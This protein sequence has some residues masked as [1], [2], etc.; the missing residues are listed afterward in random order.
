MKKIYVAGPYSDNDVLGV[1]RNIGRG[2]EYAAILFEEGFAPFAPW[3]DKEFVIQRWYHE[4]SVEQFYLYSIEWLK[5][6]DAVL[7]VENRKGMKNWEDS[8][9][10]RKEIEVAKE[11]GIPVFYDINE[12]IKHFRS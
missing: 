12:L 11:C 8:E 3:F 2:Q 10:V 7:V 1:L 9:G 5:A 6:S 4:F